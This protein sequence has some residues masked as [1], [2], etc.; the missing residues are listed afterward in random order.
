MLIKSGFKKKKKSGYSLFALHFHSNVIQ[1][2]FH[3]KYCSIG[4]SLRLLCY[5]NSLYSV[6]SIPMFFG[7]VYQEKK[8]ERDF[9]IFMSVLLF[10]L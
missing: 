2:F 5:S 9:F 8:D 7:M 10:V 1:G 6:N 3:T 4:F